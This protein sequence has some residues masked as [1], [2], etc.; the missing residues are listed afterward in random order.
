M[1]E[2]FTEIP[3]HV[4]DFQSLKMLLDELV[5]DEIMFIE[6]LSKYSLNISSEEHKVTINL[7]SE[8]STHPYLAI[9][10]ISITPS[11]Q[12]KGSIIIEWFKT[13]AK[14]KGFER[15][16]LQQVVTKEGYHFALK[17]AFSKHVSLYEEMFGKPNRIEGDYELYL[18]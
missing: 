6:G 11:N 2:K 8:F 5:Q 12:G 14:E 13:F 16:V 3:L 4:Q 9:T 10:A 18:T 15:L 17:N 7:R 1:K